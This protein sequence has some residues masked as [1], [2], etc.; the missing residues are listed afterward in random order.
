[1]SGEPA[2]FMSYARFN[3][4]HD[5]GQLSQF[6]ERLASEVQAQ[7]GRE[8]VIFQDR[9]DIAWGQ[10]WRQRIEETLDVVTL[11]LVIITPGFF[12]STECRE[13]LA[14]FL[15]RE[16]VLGGSDLILPVYYISAREMDD[17]VVRESDELARALAS[18]QFADWRELR[19][20][21]FTSP[22]VRRAIAQL[23]SRM[24]DTFWQQTPIQGRPTGSRGHQAEPVTGP[25]E[26]AGE[27][28]LV[29]AKS[30]PPAHVVDTWHHEPLNGTPLRGPSVLINLLTGHTGRGWYNGGIGCVTF[31]P[32][33][34]LLVSAGG[35]D[36]VR[37]WEA[38]TGTAVHTLTGHRSR[39]NKHID[40]MAFSP[41]GTLLATAGTDGAVR[42]WKTATWTAGP[43]LTSH[44]GWLSAV[45]FSPDG[46]MLATAGFDRTVQIWEMATWTE[47]HTL[48]GHT[49]FVSAV[50]FSPNGTMFA[51]AGNDQP[52][53]IWETA[54]WTAV[55]DSAGYQAGGK[56]VTVYGVA[57][58]ADGT[59]LAA[60]GSDNTVRI[61]E[62]ATLTAVRTLTGH[63][64][65]GW[66][67]N[68]VHGVAF[69]PDGTLLAT[70]GGDSTVRIWET[71]TWTEVRVLTGHTG[72][73]RSVV[74]SPDGALLATAG[75]DQIVRL[76]GRDQAAGE[77]K[78]A[79]N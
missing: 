12:N 16:R 72:L 11:L 58:N 38:A 15:G 36:T 2:A 61:W 70:A 50:A 47:V 7:I 57:F 41:D 3:D 53:R 24:R 19:F 37:V 21:P 14:R 75:H 6:R 1:M 35:D 39:R 66:N 40:G 49:G 43:T 45:A 23:A 62:T 28:D 8:F 26:R 27:R 31:S 71:A 44:T 22:R 69:S 76:W 74:F 79:R 60:A 10:N 59:M 68:G 65:A 5:R 78:R 32:D 64:Q 46:T 54:T 20:E 30:E 67:S 55:R 77:A 33:G 48:S 18:R 29:T 9:A 52:V 13:E 17:P 63:R 56:S 42:R 34:T 4:S 51:T 73:V 25:T